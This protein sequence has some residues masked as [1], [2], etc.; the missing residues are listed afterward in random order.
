MLKLYFNY[1]EWRKS[2][3][4]FEYVRPEYVRADLLEDIMIVSIQE[5]DD[6][7]SASIKIE[8]LIGPTTTEL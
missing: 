5:S 4:K 7:I 3:M 2:E 6:K 1:V 8:D